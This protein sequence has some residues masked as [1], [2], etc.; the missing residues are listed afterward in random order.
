VAMTHLSAWLFS[1]MHPS[2]TTVTYDVSSFSIHAA[3]VL[4]SYGS[5][6]TFAENGF[7][8]SPDECEKRLFFSKGLNHTLTA[9]KLMSLRQKCSVKL[10]TSARPRALKS[11]NITKI[12]NVEAGGNHD[13]PSI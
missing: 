5:C 1:S 7:T 2:A 4:S 6:I 11:C 12:G 9:L 13:L 10:V 3:R 8:T